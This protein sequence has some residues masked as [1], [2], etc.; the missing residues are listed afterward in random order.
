M[1]NKVTANARFVF[2]PFVGIK[3]V[4]EEEAYVK[5]TRAEYDRLLKSYETGTFM[6][7]RED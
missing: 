2:I 7:M 4:Y 1:A 3:R 5:V 6:D